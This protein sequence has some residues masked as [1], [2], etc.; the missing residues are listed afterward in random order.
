M[1]ELKV[2]NLTVAYD[3]E[4]IIS[5]YALTFLPKLRALHLENFKDFSF[6][7]NL[8]TLEILSLHGWRSEN[9]T[10]ELGRLE[11]LK[12]L[13]LTKCIFSLSFPSNVIRRLSQLEELYLPELGIEISS[14]TFLEI[15]FLTRL[16]SLS[17]GISFLHFPPDFEFPKLEKYKI[18]LSRERGILSL[19][20]DGARS[21]KIEQVFPYNEVS[22]LLGN[23]ECL[24]VSDIKDEYVKCLTNRTQQKV[25][26]P[27]ILRSLKQVRIERCNT[28]KVV[29][30]M[31]EVE[32][33]EAPFLSNLKI[34][35]LKGLPYLSCI[36]ELPTQHV[37]LESLV[38]LTIE[39]CSRLKSLFSLSL[40]QSLILLEKLD[41]SFCD[42][43]TQIVAELEEISSTINSHT[44][45]C[46]PK[47]TMLRISNCDGLEYI[48][49]TSL[50][51]QGLQGLTLTIRDCPQLKQVFRVAKGNMLQHQQCLISLLSFSV[52][53]C[54]QLTDSVVHLEAEKVSIEAVRLSAFK[55]W[56]KTSKQLK[57]KAIKD[58]NLVPEANEDGLNG[59]TSLQLRDC[60]YLECLVDTTTT[61]TK[62]GPTSAFTHLETLF[63]ADMLR[64]EALC[65]G[66]PAQGFLKNLKHLEVR[67]CSKFQVVD[68]LLHNREENQE[69]PL[70]N[71][72][73]LILYE[74]PEL[75]WIFKGSPHSF[76]LQSLKVVNIDGCGKLKSLFS[77]SLIQSLVLLEQLKIQDCHELVT[78][79]NDGEIE[80]KT[81]SLPLRLPK[82]KTLFINWCSKL[83]CV[84]P[85]TL[86]QGLPALASLSVCDCHELKQV[87]GMP[88]EKDGV[89]H[90][91]SLLLPS[92]QDLKLIS[93]RN[94]TSF[95]P[96]NYIVKAP[97]LKRLK[98]NDC[99][100]VTNLPI[101]QANNELQL[102]LKEI[103]LFAFKELLCN[104]KDLILIDI[105]DHKN[106]V[107]DLVDL[108]HLHGLISLTIKN[109]RSGECLVDTSQAMMEFK[110]N[111]QPPKCFLQNLKILRVFHCENFSKIFRVNDG[112][113]SKA[114][115]LPN[116]KFVEIKRCPSL[117]YVFPHASVGGFSHLQKVQLVELRKLRS[118]VR[119]NNFL[120]APTSEVL[121]IQKCSAFTNYTFH[122]E[123]KKCVSVKE[124]TFAMEDIDGEDVKSCNMVNTQLGQKSSDFKN[125]TLGTSEQLDLFN[126]VRLREVATNLR[127]LTI[128]NC[129]NLTYIFPVMFIQ[130]LSQL[131]FLKIQSCENLK[132]I[133]GSDDILASSSS[134]QGPQLEMKMVF[135]RL[136]QIVLNYL[137]K[138]ESFSPV[139]YHL[140]FPCL[141]LLDI[142]QCPKLITSFSAD[143]LTLIV[144]AKT[145][146]LTE[147]RFSTGFDMTQDWLQMQSDEPGAVSGVAGSCWSKLP[148]GWVKCNINATLCIE[149]NA[150][151][152][153]AIAR[154]AKG[155]VNPMMA[156][157]FAEL[158]AVK[159]NVSGV[160][161]EYEAGCGGVLRDVDGVARALFLGPIAAKDSIA[162]EVGVIIIALDV[163]LV[164]GLKGKGSLV[165]EIGSN[166]MFSWIENK[167]LRPFILQS[168]FKD[169]KNRMDRVGN[170]S[171]SKAEKHKNDLAFALA[172][173]GTKRPRMFKA[174]WLIYHE[175]C[176]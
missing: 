18:C 82:L 20:L 69:H 11:N 152:W 163:Y 162:A 113:E 174:W 83:E 148:V 94:L 99:S 21:L 160:P 81:S 151:G 122:K 78:I 150:A 110:C 33:N 73:S 35:H 75:R 60:L 55:E 106:L 92:L 34:L 133:I 108:E 116:L 126:V 141:D 107:P 153:S 19:M 39:R 66:Q 144:H 90:H 130:N 24:Q 58:H 14:D 67:E 72:Q 129:N 139:G 146:E 56:F 102:T 175:R 96:Q 166:E 118:I 123:V 79:F 170:V 29:F 63:I 70:S 124:L 125:I 1:R 176:S 101:Q 165:I 103:G 172:L 120:E 86:A 42:E 47:L 155:H 173:A 134:A 112:R 85:I 2:L 89:Q 104:T 168:I 156:P 12:I 50:A 46:F 41:I 43:L 164:M 64:L 23:L 121:Y 36:W 44:S 80:S 45:L 26:V 9:L 98:A 52:S 161:N 53:G 3:S 62:N 71:L 87:F 77:S 25:P 109:W 171:F 115:Y 74:L 117:E 68:E 105:E 27:M 59:V 157:K 131:S 169:I 32:E 13:D 119:G 31:E 15:N 143:Y 88:N 16:T 40:G 149:E 49:P 97:S 147:P 142:S 100:K 95:V 167:R 154:D 138:L 91:G 65:K 137:S 51:P 17:L 132:E 38:E 145:D 28:I 5:L 6:L 61:A 30:Q 57:V 48:F 4:R 54:P 158:Y 76:T 114:R 128:H 22:Q 84:V 136:K 159:F 93:L 37:R 8:K 140:E 135:P 10:N 7:G 127:E 111:D